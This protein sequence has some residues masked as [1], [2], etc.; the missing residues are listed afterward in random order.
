MWKTTILL[1]VL[2][3]FTLA[4]SC[5]KRE[6][7]YDAEIK[8]GFSLIINDSIIYNSNSIDFYD[9]SS[10]LIYLKSGNIFSYSN[11]GPFSIRVDDEEIYTGQMFPVYS[12][13][14][15]TGSY[16]RCSPSFYNDYIIPIGFNKIIDSEG[17]SND[18]PRNDSRI[19][20]ALE[21]YMQYKKGLSS[22]ILSVKKISD[23][24]IEIMLELKNLDS[25]NIL[26]L[27]P[28]KMG[29]ELFHY[30]TNGLIIKDSLNNSY[31]HK[32]TIEEPSPWDSWKIDWLTVINGNETKTISVIY[33]NFDFLPSGEYTALFNY[34]G[35]SFQIKKEELQQNNARIWLGELNNSL[36]V[37]SRQ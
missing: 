4:Q 19:V 6:D 30:F 24:K 32:L 21:K 35:L 34:P 26:F 22:K 16:I 29:L 17:N 23:N 2:S 27:D 9:F 18:D 31:T 33:D 12:S 13:Y 25:D 5:E 28:D 8:D 7:K 1:Y 11:Q 3:M 10:H 36:A 20:E 15:P 37:T 14:Y